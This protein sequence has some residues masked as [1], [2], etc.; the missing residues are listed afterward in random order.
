[1]KG[2]RVR[3]IIDIG[4]GSTEFVVEADKAGR[5]VEVVETRGG[6][7]I[8]VRLLTRT[9]VVVK[10]DR[11]MASRVIAMVEERRGDDEDEPDQ[12]DE[13]PPRL[14]GPPAS[15]TLGPSAPVTDTGREMLEGYRDASDG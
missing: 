14:F 13:L 11:Y 9:D 5:K 3:V 2:D 8:E 6:R 12:P 4:T 1:M 15:I 7:M 10:T